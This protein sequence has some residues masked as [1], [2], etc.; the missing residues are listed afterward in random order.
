MLDLEGIRSTTLSLLPDEVSKGEQQKQL[1]DYSPGKTEEERGQEA[2]HWGQN[3]HAYV[4]L[5]S[6]ITSRKRFKWPPANNQEEWQQFDSDIIEI[7]HMATKG[8][9]D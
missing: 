2:T 7:L 9:L 8:D 4:S 6:V 3:L 5:V 1:V